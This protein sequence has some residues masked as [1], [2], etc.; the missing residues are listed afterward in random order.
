MGLQQRESKYWQNTSLSGNVSFNV[1]VSEPRERVNQR[2][3]RFC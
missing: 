3:N 1:F 2:E